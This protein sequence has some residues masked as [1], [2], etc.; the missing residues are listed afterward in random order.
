MTP[1]INR[2][3]A[4]RQLGLCLLD[5]APNKVAVPVIVLA[6]PRGGVPVAI[7]VA[8]ALQAPLDVFIVRKIGVPSHPELAMG[9]IA[10]GGVIVKNYDLMRQMG[11]DERSFARVAQ[12]ER[13]E[14]ERREISYRGGRERLAVEGRICLIVDDGIAT[15]ASMQAAAIAV[16]KQNPNRIVVAAPV[17][18]E[19]VHQNFQHTAD[20]VVTVYTPREFSSVGLWY[21]DFSQTSDE[22]VRELLEA[23]RSP[24]NWFKPDG[25]AP[26]AFH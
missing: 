14:L 5:Y 7:E 13:A 4:G 21:E 6:L 2:R 11:I 10:S 22:E 8:R 17:G 24:S 1:F 12:L 20:E 9:A 23:S 15:G 19:A 26:P 25:N 3:D 18:A 16:R